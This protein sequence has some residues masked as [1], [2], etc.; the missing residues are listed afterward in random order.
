MFSLAI[1]GELDKELRAD[2][3]AFARA[4]STVFRRKGTIFQNRLRRQ[5]QQATGS[6]QLGNAVRKS[7]RPPRGASPDIVVRVYSNALYKRPGGLVDLITVLD[8]GA[9]ISGGKSML[10]GGRL[11]QKGGKRF[12]RARSVTIKKVLDVDGLYQQTMADIDIQVLREWDRLAEKR[13]A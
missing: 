5:I 10:I 3:Q 7:V 8:T 1:K 6:T 13:G 4:R 2:A 12:A 9:T 11:A